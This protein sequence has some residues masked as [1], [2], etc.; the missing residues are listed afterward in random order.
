MNSGKEIL[1]SAAAASLLPVSNGQSGTDLP[2][3]LQWMPP[4]K[5]TVQPVTS[6]EPFEMDVTSAIAAKAN[7]D[8]QAMLAAER[9]GAGS[10]PFGDFNHEDGEAAFD[11]LEF[12]WGGEDPKSGGVRLKVKWTP[13]GETRVRAG[14]WR[15]LSPSWWM[16]KTTHAFRGIGLNIGGLVNRPAFQGIQA[17]AKSGATR[18]S[19]ASLTNQQQPMTPEDK[20]QFDA[21][22][23]SVTKLTETVT[24]LV[25]KMNAAARE[26][27]AADPTIVSI[28]A[29]LKAL[30]T[31]DTNIIQANARKTVE[32]IG[33]KA[34]RIASQDKDTIE[35]WVGAIAANAK[36]ADA[37]GKMPVNPAFVTVVQNASAGGSSVT[38]GTDHEF[39]VKA[40]AY[41][42]TNNLDELQAQA[43]YATTAE[44]RALYDQYRAS[45]MPARA[46]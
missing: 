20:Q 35:F 43:K 28:E 14:A 24:G 45:I 2:T 46:A 7:A 19:D 29:R 27:P 33:V 1:C 30:E 34:G 3:D 13:A 41:G 5:L 10:K 22:Q 36:A 11:P 26:N 40:R 32:E 16:D 9:S 37:L 21:L 15:Y 17:F 18:A 31:S 23:G 38:S 8:L 44:G 39:L 6:D 25:E 12:S 42:K 4:G